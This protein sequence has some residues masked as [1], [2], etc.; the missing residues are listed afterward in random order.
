MA[1]ER[2]FRTRLKELMSKINKFSAA[3]IVKYYF[4]DEVRDNKI[5]P[6]SIGKAPLIDRIESIYLGDIN[7]ATSFHSALEHVE[8]KFKTLSSN[9]LSSVDIE[10]LTHSKKATLWLFLNI[11]H[12]HEFDFK[13]SILDRE[14]Q[15]Q[16]IINHIQLK[17]MNLISQRKKLD[18]YKNEWAI[19]HNSFNLT[20]VDELNEQMAEH[21][22]NYLCG[23]RFLNSKVITEF[24]VKHIW[25]TNQF[26]DAYV[27]E[28]QCLIFGY[29]SFIISSD[30]AREAIEKRL[31]DII[32][33]KKQRDNKSV[34]YT[35][36]H[37]QLKKENAQKLKD[38]ARYKNMTISEY[39]NQ[40]IEND[41]SHYIDDEMKEEEVSSIRDKFERDGW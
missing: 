13:G 17:R 30:A 21:I 25:Y 6:E 12:S 40:V 19:K 4:E 2:E 32:N 18:Q 8:K 22:W 34:S 14:L 29:F 11:A 36:K 5:R 41:Y 37:F 39:L 35:N 38:V 27:E 28:I 24:R 1:F 31:K 16:Y 33:Q 9:T 20:W 10:W 3:P 7:D 23:N 26:R 15:L